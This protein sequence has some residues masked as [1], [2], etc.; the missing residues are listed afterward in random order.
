MFKGHNQRG[1]TKE[2]IQITGKNTHQVNESYSSLYQTRNLFLITN[3]SLNYQGFLTGLSD[4][5]LRQA[6][7][8]TVLAINRR[9]L[10]LKGIFSLLVFH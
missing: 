4:L 2:R 8:G 3:G 9:S 7:V 10:N 5:T 1:R 6:Q